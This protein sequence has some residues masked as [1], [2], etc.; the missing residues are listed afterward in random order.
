MTWTMLCHLHDLAESQHSDPLISFD[1]TSTMS[2]T[3]SRQQHTCAKVVCCPCQV[4]V[5][6][7][8]LQHKAV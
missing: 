6:K 7:W 2:S 3:A 1:L 5:N 4:V 8:V